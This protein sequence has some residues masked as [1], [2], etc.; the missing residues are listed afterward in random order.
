MALADVHD[1]EALI[2]RAFATGGELIAG[3]SVTRHGWSW[4]TPD[5]RYRHHLC[6]LSHGAAGIGWA[7]LELFA[8]T[9]DERFRTAAAGAF[10]Y[11]RS[12]LETSS[13]R[14]PDLRIA[15]QRRKAATHIPSPAAGTWCHGEGGIALT[16]MRAIDLLGAEGCGD[17]ARLALATIRREL[18][19]ALPYEI[20]DL[21]LCH[22]AA[23][24]AEV[25]LC[26]AAM[27]GEGSEASSPATE[28]GDVALDRYEAT[29]SWPCDAAGGTTPGLFRGISGIAWWLLRL[30]DRRIPS[31][32]TMPSL[33]LTT[34][35][36][37]A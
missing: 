5:R 1:D 13:G 34:I 7:L 8:A 4:A 24:Q 21:T 31:P 26:G 20:A 19:G 6:G 9:G 15:G 23:G 12:W 14:W 10:A 17:D 37:G 29:S 22:G 16:R 11:E 36:D 2:G 30:H 3:A 27:F 35:R 33:R 25:L 32:V 28:L 18:A